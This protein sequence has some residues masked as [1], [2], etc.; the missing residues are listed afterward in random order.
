MTDTGWG[1]SD[2]V[3]VLAGTALATAAAL[4]GVDG[5]LRIALV[6]PLVVVL[7]GYAL[8]SLLFPVGGEPLGGALPFDWSGGAPDDRPGLDG[9]SRL[10]LAVALTAAV[11]PLVALVANFSATGLAPVPVV[12]IL[13][14]TTGAFVLFAAVR[15]LRLPADERF[16][17]TLAPPERLGWS[18]PSGPFRTASK[19]ERSVPNIALAVGVLVLL[20]SVG[21]AAVAPP[22]G[23]DYTEFRVA[24]DDM[25]ANTDTLYRS[26]FPAGETTPA[27]VVLTN[28]EGERTNYTVVAQVEVV[29]GNGGNATVTERDAVRRYRLTL[30]HGDSRTLSHEFV[31]PARTERVRAAYHLYRGRAPAR[32]VESTAYRSVYV[33]E[34]GAG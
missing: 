16:A 32:A 4:S 8:V 3:L 12:V 17:P 26:S 15:R 22:Q 19:W 21:Y 25:T 29:D 1:F 20:S 18:A 31:A 10:G 9:V 2:L 7:P 33:R 14:T 24:T 34:R 27:E 23:P 5:V 28:H 13:A 30:D 6:L 11:V